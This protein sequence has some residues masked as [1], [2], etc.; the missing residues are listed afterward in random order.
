MLSKADPIAS[1]ISP[2]TQSNIIQG[3][4]QR[5]Q[6]RAISLLSPS[7][8]LSSLF[9]SYANRAAAL[10]SASP[11]SSNE[12]E[13]KALQNDLAALREENGKLALENHKI[14][15]KL[16]AA[17]ASQ[18]AFHSQMSSLIEVN[19]S[20]EGEIQSL[21]KEL[22]A[23]KDL[24]D[25]LTAD[26]HE[27]KSVC[28]TQISDLEVGSRSS[29]LNGTTVLIGESGE[30]TQQAELEETVVEQQVRISK[31]ERQ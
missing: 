31:L 6:D 25:L 12:S 7:P 13:W 1:P 30:Q 27:E 2:V 14:L 3:I 8:L 11:T 28:Q 4:L 19:K 24:Y 10:E 15:R 16:G 22:A 18:E 17:E 5:E 20:Q 23:V 21:R 26:S 9:L 29:R